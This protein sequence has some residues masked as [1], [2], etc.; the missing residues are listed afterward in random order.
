MWSFKNKKPS[1]L[2]IPY[3]KAWDKW[4]D[5]YYRSHTENYVRISDRLSKMVPREKYKEL[6]V[7]EYY[8]VYTSK[9]KQL[10][11]EKF[12]KLCYLLSLRKFRN[13]MQKF[14]SEM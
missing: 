6:T 14:R 9:T 2:K 13:E 4:I 7:Q 12:A 8:K 10:D 5:Y 3:D 1:S 11:I